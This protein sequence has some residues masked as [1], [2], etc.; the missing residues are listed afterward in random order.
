M[1]G[2]I[3]TRLDVVDEAASTNAL[4]KARARSGDSAGSVVIAEY[5]SAGRGRLG[6][7]W[8]APPRSGLTMSVLVRPY[9]VDVNRWPWIPLLAGLAVAAAMRREAVVDAEVKWPNDVLV[10]GRKIAGVLV[11]RVE[12]PTQRAAAVIGIGVNVSLRRDEL[13]VAT[14]TS[15]ALEGSATTDRTLLA[16]AVLRALEGLLTQ[17][18]GA[19]GDPA[20]G[21]SAAY[22]E[23]CGTLGR[24]V[25]VEL[26]SGSSVEGDAVG[27][28]AAGRLLV[29]SGGTEHAYGAGDV[30]HLC[31][32]A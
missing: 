7:T 11:E 15:L 6:R 18:Q 1:P 19:A 27:I 29:R 5:Q 21:L 10:G 23:A 28:D 22:I 2:S 16:K 20:G 3:W 13:P 24:P 32:L 17:W 9:D 4:L 30:V 8:T 31:P 26:P 25:R 12:S 14:A